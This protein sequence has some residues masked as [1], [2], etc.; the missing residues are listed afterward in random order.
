M[1]ALPEGRPHA[2]GVGALDLLQDPLVLRDGAQTLT[3]LRHLGWKLRGR[4]GAAP[5]GRR[6]RAARGASAR[7]RG[8]GRGGCRGGGGRGGAGSQGARG[9]RPG[10]RFRSSH[11][12]GTKVSSAAAR[13]RAASPSAL[14]RYLPLVADWSLAWL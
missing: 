1:R 14:P 5:R 11:L 8:K 13:S 12:P 9:A 6:E 3:A 2:G 4:R 10:T 7:G